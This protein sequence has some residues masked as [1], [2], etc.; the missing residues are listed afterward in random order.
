LF[1][2]FLL[3]VV[4]VAGVA[5]L[6]A[7]ICLLDLF[8]CFELVGRFVAAKYEQFLAEGDVVVELLLLLGVLVAVQ[9]LLLLVSL[10][11]LDYVLHDGIVRA[12]LLRNHSAQQNVLQVQPEGQGADMRLHQQQVEDAADQRLFGQRAVLLGKASQDGHEGWKQ[13]RLRHLRPPFPVDDHAE[14]PG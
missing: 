7:R 5:V 14:D 9:L 13:L 11:P 10:D 4:S 3:P 6:L 1:Q 8:A 12:V 2:P